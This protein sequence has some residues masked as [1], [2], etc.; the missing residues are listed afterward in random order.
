MALSLEFKRAIVA[1]AVTRLSAGSR[2]LT[3]S[4]EWVAESIGDALYPSYSGE[5]KI[6]MILEYR[7]KILGVSN[8][9]E[10]E[11]RLT[12]AR[13]HYD[14]CLDWVSRNKIKPEDSARLL[15]KT[16]IQKR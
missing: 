1:A 7:K 15:I 13:Y 12:V 5:K 9:K 3:A 8:R 10:V 2:N 4:A 16:M 6:Q 14:Q 11:N